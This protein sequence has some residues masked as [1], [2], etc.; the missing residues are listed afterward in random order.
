MK[1]LLCLLGLTVAFPLAIAPEARACSTPVVI[2]QALPEAELSLAEAFAPP[3]ELP[4]PT[5]PCHR[6]MDEV[7]REL[8]LAALRQADQIQDPA[9]KTEA[10]LDLYWTYKHF[11]LPATW[12]LLEAAEQQAQQVEAAPQRL[13]LLID[14][15]GAYRCRD[16]DDEAM[17]LKQAAVMEESWRLLQVETTAD[18]VPSED[19]HELLYWYQQQGDLAKVDWLQERVQKMQREQLMADGLSEAEAT[20]LIEGH[21]GAESITRDSSLM[22]LQS[23]IEELRVAIDREG[24]QTLDSDTIDS[25]RQLLSQVS[26]PIMQ[27]SMSVELAQLLIQAQQF[28]LARDVTYDISLPQDYTT[29]LP[30]MGIELDESAIKA[31]L[32]MVGTAIPHVSGDMAMAFFDSFPTSDPNGPGLQAAARVWAA[33]EAWHAENKDAA[34]N[35]VD[36]A[37]IQARR[38]ENRNHQAQVLMLAGAM[39]AEFGQEEEAKALIEEATA[40]APSLRTLAE[41]FM[42]IPSEEA[43]DPGPQAIEAYGSE[44]EDEYYSLYED[45]S[46]AIETKDLA[47]AE[48]LAQQFDADWEQASLLVELAGLQSQRQQPEK[49]LRSLETA[50]ENIEAADLGFEGTVDTMVYGIIAPFVYSGG[51]ITLL[52]EILDILPGEPVELEAIRLKALETWY[53]D[54]NQ[55]NATREVQVLM[56]HVDRLSDASARTQLWNRHLRLFA[57]AGAWN[58]AIAHIA[59][60]PSEL[61]QVQQL[62]DLAE[63]YSNQGKQLD[64]ASLMKLQAAA[65]SL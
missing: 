27:F 18:L 31:G 13:G 52:H 48:A 3:Q 63:T 58:E 64:A 44:E 9:E 50:V 62:N 51:S 7:S 21:A 47:R 2:A 59:Q 38:L 53:V 24:P 61:S 49:A 55:P 41:Q 14:I 11:E 20:A 30:A 43:P 4:V 39:Q 32:V 25:L 56:E 36:K 19:L 26:E 29:F 40:I 46:E 34:Q 60:L 1:K 8:V 37:T 57:K 23:Q 45:F 12:Q 6:Q 42:M 22:Q 5:Q 35:L 16:E 28:D 17:A 54:W 15:A 10:I 33:Q 65:Q